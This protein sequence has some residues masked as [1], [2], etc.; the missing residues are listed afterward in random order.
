MRNS[1]EIHRLSL[2]HYIENRGRP[3][4]DLLVKNR[5]FSR[6]PLQ[7]IKT[8]FFQ[9][10]V[11]KQPLV[12]S[13]CGPSE[14]IG[15]AVTYNQFVALA[16]CCDLVICL[17]RRG[18]DAELAAEKKIE[19]Y[20]ASTPKYLFAF[21]K[22][23]FQC[24]VNDLRLLRYVDIIARQKCINCERLRE[25]CLQTRKPVYV[26]NLNN[27]LILY[28]KNMLEEQVN[29]A[30][31]PHAALGN[32]IFPDLSFVNLYIANDN[33]EQEKLKKNG[34]KARIYSR[35][36]KSS[37][38]FKPSKTGHYFILL[39][40]NYWEVDTVYFAQLDDV[41][42]AV[43]FHPSTFLPMRRLW[44]IWFLIK[45]GI[46][47]LETR[48]FQLDSRV[49]SASTS[50]VFSALR[51]GKCVF[52]LPLA[53]QSLDHYGFDS[54]LLEIDC[55]ETEANYEQQKSEILIDV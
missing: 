27:P 52:K 45:T 8:C 21:V 30:H 31:V 4:F 33:G 55:P 50:V 34:W 26:S 43:K 44:R 40:K 11:V 12:L 48:V 10:T 22:S 24:L 15:I 6:L 7:F 47:V 36:K 2:R 3:I 9:T 20:L 23:I 29:W 13:G 14:R 54:K 19:F 16:E 18:Y 42:I 28:I 5:S 25:L 1:F 41:K 17:D 38:P 46:P 53:T 37:R 32:T 49:F 35:K 51:E 39:P